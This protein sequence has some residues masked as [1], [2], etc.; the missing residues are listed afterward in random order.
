MR[1]VPVPATTLEMEPETLAVVKVM[2]DVISRAKLCFDLSL[3]L[4]LAKLR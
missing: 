4:L 3:G 2:D 1:N